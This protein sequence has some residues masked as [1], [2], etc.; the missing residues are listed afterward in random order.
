MFVIILFIFL[1]LNTRTDYKLK[2][3]R[4]ENLK[5]C[6]HNL[7]CE[8][9]SCLT[10]ERA[11]AGQIMCMYN[12]DLLKRQQLPQEINGDHLNNKHSFPQILCLCALCGDQ[13]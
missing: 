12:G 4:Q 5:K 6:V 13:E 9:F 3:T 7:K 1:I 10:R 2:E 11:H 8:I